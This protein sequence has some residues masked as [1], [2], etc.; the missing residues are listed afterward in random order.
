[1]PF[2]NS[3]VQWN[4]TGIPYLDAHLELLKGTRLTP[5]LLLPP[6]RT[7]RQGRF[8]G[9]GEARRWRSGMEHLN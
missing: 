3:C 4:D 1:M 8:H 7:L 2:S 5:A 6:G 9:R